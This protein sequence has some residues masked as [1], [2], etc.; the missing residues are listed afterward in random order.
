MNNATFSSACSC[1]VTAHLCGEPCKLLG[2]RGCLED[3]T[4]VSDVTAF[5][6]FVFLHIHRSSNMLRMIT[7][8]LRSSIC[9]ARYGLIVLNATVFCDDKKLVAMCPQGD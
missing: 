1:V 6:S 5:S 4:K 9:V 7:C 3:C 8:A 2:R